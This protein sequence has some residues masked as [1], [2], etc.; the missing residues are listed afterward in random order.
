MANY[1][2][3]FVVTDVESGGLPDRLKKEATIE[4]ALTEIALVSIDN[5]NLKIDKKSSW[6]IKPY[7][8]DLIYD[9]VAA[10]V[11]GISKQMYQKEGL[12]LEVVYNN[13]KSF[14]LKETDKTCKP[15][16]IIQ[17]KS[18]DTPFIANL[19]KIFEDD[20]FKYIDSIEDTMVWSRRKWP[21]EGKH[22]LATIAQRCGLDHVESHR[23]LPDTI[24]TA[25]VWIYFMKCLRGEGAIGG[26]IEKPKRFREGF[27][28]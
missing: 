18:F 24:I 7:S 3:R 11:S 22:N 2:N 8:D 12:E 6:L 10:K 25:D 26:Q 17:N 9:P 27:K 21:M 14:L 23:A 4:V 1:S 28:F 16:L 5:E 15:I 20:L 19:F 13:V